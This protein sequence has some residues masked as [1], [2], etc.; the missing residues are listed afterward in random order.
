MTSTTC[1]RLIGAPS[2]TLDVLLADSEREGSRFVR[3]LVDEWA[4]GANRFDR[5][6]E[7]LF[8]ARIG[9]RLVGICGLNVDPYAAAANVGRV[10]RLYVLSAYRRL[11]VGRQLVLAVLQAARGRFD[12]LRLRT[13]NP[14]AA[15]LY[16]SLGFTPSTAGDDCTHVIDLGSHVSEVP[17]P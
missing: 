15:R 4:T 2:E 13:T 1:E 5:P 3:R 6:G 14:A 16:E 8:T 12:V 9:D 11:G 17:Q 10:R 7:A